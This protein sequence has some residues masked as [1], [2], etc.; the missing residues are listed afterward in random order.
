MTTTLDKNIIPV[1][2]VDEMKTAYGDYALAVIIG[3]A[4]PDI[5]DGLKPVTRRILTAMKWLNLKPD[6]RFMKAAR[7]EGETMGRLHPQGGAYG[8]MVTVAA[9]YKNNI[10]YINGHGNWG[11]PTDNAAAPR[12]TE[13]KLTEF[14]WD[15]LLDDFDICETKPN[16]DDSTREPIRLEA[17]IP[18]VLLNGVEGIGVGVATKVA[19]HNITDVCKA[20]EFVAKGNKKKAAETLIPDFPGGCDIV[21]SE[22]IKEYAVTG[23]GSMKLRAKCVEGVE[24]RARSERV[25]LTFTNLPYQ[26]NTESIGDQIKKGLEQGKISGIAEVRDES[27]R[28]GDRLLI[29]LKPKVKA[30]DVVPYLYQFTDLQSTFS[31][32]SLF[33]DGTKPVELAPHQVVERWLVWRLQRLVVKFSSEKE[34]LID[35]LHIIDGLMKALDKIDLVISI[36]RKAKDKTE[37]KTKLMSSRSLKLSAAQAE[38]V[39]D[40]RLRQLT[41]MDSEELENEKKLKLD[42]VD[43]LSILIENE[44]ERKSYVVNEVKQIAKKFGFSRKCKMIEVDEAPV[45]VKGAITR[46]SAPKMRFMKIDSKKGIIEQLKKPRGANL[47]LDKDKVVFITNNGM[48]KKVPPTFK[49]PLYDGPTEV[50]TRGTEPEISTRNY[51]VVFELDNQIKAMVLSGQDLCKTTSKGKSFLPNDAKLIYMGEDSYTVTFKSK[52]KKPLVLNAKTAKVARPGAKGNKICSIA[53]IA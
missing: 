36:I 31:S 9:P 35:R 6:G 21:K 7:V 26:T 47:I 49:G 13:C 37:A 10:T 39:L 16:Y 1:N 45:V 41:N 27:D 17:K 19:P 32:R 40:M 53:D 51:L 30:V 42:R 14:A 22:S 20:V 48:F 18:T 38:A 25:T 34:K 44:N 3:R 5:Y 46:T 23:I 28:E 33:I 43:V 12:Y 15:I 2:I 52:R 50:I 4:I 8:A 24:K 29:I 11:S